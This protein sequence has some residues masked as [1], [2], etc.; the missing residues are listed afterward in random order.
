MLSE[1]GGLNMANYFIHFPGG[2]CTHAAEK[3]IYPYLQ[4]E[5]DGSIVAENSIKPIIKANI[6]AWLKEY[7]KTHKSKSIECTVHK[8]GPGYYI[9][10]GQLY[11]TLWEIK[12]EIGVMTI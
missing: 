1:K 5:F 9:N 2:A 10:V 8:G 6:D 3:A 4:D 11:L 7:Q 12:H